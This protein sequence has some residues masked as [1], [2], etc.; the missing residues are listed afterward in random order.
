MNTQSFQP[1]Y[2][3]LL[4]YYRNRILQQE[5]K[6]GDKIDSINKIMSRHKVSRDTAKLVL[7]KLNEEGLAVTINGRGTFVPHQTRIN[8]TWAVII[9]FFSSN[10]EHLLNCLNDEASNRSR[11]FEYFLHYNN[12]K[13]ET[14]LVTSLI[15]KGY[16]TVLVAPNYDESKTTE[17][18]SR[19]IPGKTKLLL[20]DNTM[21]QTSMNYVIQSYDLGI[22]RALDYIRQKTNKNILFVKNEIWKGKNL[23]NELIE[24]SLFTYANNPTGQQR[25]ITTGN[26]SAINRLFC[27]KQNIGGIISH[28]DT[29]TAIIVG[30]LIQEGI[31]IP[32]ELV[33]VNYGNTELTRYFTPALTAIDCKYE[34]MATLV[35]EFIDT[36]STEKKSFQF[37]IQ[38][39][40]IIRNT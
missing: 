21:T 18:Y 29:N 24:N 4:N 10:M 13:E 32:D 35:G 7:H 15:N 2:Q 9:P 11:Q 38:P 20:I 8:K 19:L 12:Y 14:R 37:V 31:K 6:P 1:I 36:D 33:I 25:F 30:K 3:R 27:E 28:N 23:L 16:E 34:K 17:F 40:L 22:K 5:Y 39:E 26:V